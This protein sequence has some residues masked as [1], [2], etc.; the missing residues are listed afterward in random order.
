[1]SRERGID[2]GA[3]GLPPHI[4]QERGPLSR[5]DREHRLRGGA[6]CRIVCLLAVTDSDLAGVEPDL[7]AGAGRAAVAA[8]EPARVPPVMLRR[9]THTGELTLRRNA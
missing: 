2:H 3:T 7:Y 5:S 1:M 9:K 8:L 6:G 4:G